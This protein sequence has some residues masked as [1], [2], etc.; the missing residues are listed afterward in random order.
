MQTENFDVVEFLPFD[1]TYNIPGDVVTIDSID[2]TGVDPLILG[3]MAI[4]NINNDIRIRGTL[5]YI[6]PRTFKY[7]NKNNQPFSFTRIKDIPTD[8]NGLMTYTPP[9]FDTI[10]FTIT[11]SYS[12]NAAIE[13]VKDS[14]VLNITL[15]RNEP[16]ITRVLAKIMSQ[17]K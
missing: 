7:V 8:Y 10:L 16:V 5:D 17:K 4:T 14:L 6:F 13:V 1:K 11:I 2:T 15:R 9:S 3:E 12:V